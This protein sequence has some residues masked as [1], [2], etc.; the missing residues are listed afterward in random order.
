MLEL[1]LR[2]LHAHVP[3]LLAECK[4]AERAKTP[5]REEAA[6]RL[7]S[8]LEQALSLSYCAA[9]AAAGV[10]ID[11]LQELSDATDAFP[12]S[13]TLRERKTLVSRSRALLHKQKG[14]SAALLML[15]LASQEPVSTGLPAQV[16]ALRWEDLEQGVPR[17]DGSP[18]Q[19]GLFIEDVN[20]P[21][22]RSDAVLLTVAEHTD[23]VN[24]VKVLPGGKLLASVSEDGDVLICSM[25]TGEVKCTL[26]GHNDK[27]LHGCI[28]GGQ[29]VERGV[30]NE[31]CPL[32]HE[33]T[34]GHVGGVTCLDV[35][36]TGKLLVTGGTDR[37]VRVWKRE[38]R[39]SRYTLWKQSSPGHANQ[40]K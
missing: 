38:G 11:L 39:S 27:R 14:W 34:G 6:T 25:A 10:S 15:Q 5:D 28:C 8:R 3:S 23:I 7:E 33:A 12:Q 22:Q 1:N 13:K 36:R 30:A 18:A 26:A 37:T 2:R 19:S 32:L 40:V 17:R 29:D 24:G 9:K 31:D 21:E 20:R 4:K 35:S 16:Q